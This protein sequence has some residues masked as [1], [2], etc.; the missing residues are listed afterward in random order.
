M[1]LNSVIHHEMNS[2]SIRAKQSIKVQGCKQDDERETRDHSGVPGNSASSYLLLYV[3]ACLAAGRMNEHLS[4]TM[5]PSRIPLAKTLNTLEWYLRLQS[6][7]STFRHVQCLD[8]ALCNSRIR[9][10]F[11]GKRQ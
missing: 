1:C 4:V 9:E 2:E 8:Q 7:S 6:L 5:T 11:T 3:S 10:S